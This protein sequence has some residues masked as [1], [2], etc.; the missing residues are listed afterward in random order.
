MR[1]IVFLAKAASSG[2]RY[3]TESAECKPPDVEKLNT[4]VDGVS[5]LKAIITWFEQERI[6]R[7]GGL[8]NGDKFVSSD[9]RHGY[10]KF[11]WEGEDLL[12]DNSEVY[13]EGKFINPSPP[14]LSIHET[15]ARK[16]GWLEKDEDGDVYSLGANIQKELLNDAV[17]SEKKMDY[18]SRLENKAKQPVFWNVEKDHFYLSGV[19][20]WR[21]LNVNFAFQS[22]VG[23]KARTLLVYSDLV[24]SSIVGNRVTDLLREV[25]YERTGKGINYFEPL[26]MQYLPV[27]SDTIDIVE[28]QVGELDGELVKFGKGDTIVTLH[29]KPE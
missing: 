17:P 22:L 28:T 14:Y 20:N 7:R 2:M 11:R 27:R 25:R 13:Y 12:I 24:R 10:V 29:F 23:H 4:V 15:L 1:W 19:C 3:R 6:M 16:M 26:H 8:Q 18:D 9:G 5:F 21:L